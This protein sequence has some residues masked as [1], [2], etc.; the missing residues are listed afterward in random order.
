MS[1]II[2]F[3]TAVKLKQAGFPQPLPEVG[4]VWYSLVR[5]D[6]VINML[7]LKRQLDHS[8]P[9]YFKDSFGNRHYIEVFD[10]FGIYAPTVGDLL[11]EMPD[12]RLSYYKDLFR[13]VYLNMEATDNVHQVESNEH[14]VEACAKL[15]L[16][17]KT[18]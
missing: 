5:G 2:S 4:Q 15:Y 11:K 14:S 8:S 9:E 18:I 17:R 12:C 3:E 1:N 7:V 6:T 16:K 13:A 10:K